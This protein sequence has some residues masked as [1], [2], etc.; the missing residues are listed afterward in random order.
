MKDFTKLARGLSGFVSN[1][2]TKSI[3]ILSDDEQMSISVKGSAEELLS[4]TNE[5]IKSIREEFEKK[6]GKPLTEALLKTVLFDDERIAKENRKMDKGEIPAWLKKLME[7][8]EEDDDEEGTVPDSD[9]D[10]D[11]EDEARA[12]AISRLADALHDA[13]HGDLRDDLL[14]SD[15]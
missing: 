11:E 13:L 10:E 1:T 8:E 12:K 2:F 5:L 3:V 4:M 6:L 7:L 9:P 14:D 15:D